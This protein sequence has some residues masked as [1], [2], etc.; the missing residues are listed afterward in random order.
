VSQSAW[1]VSLPEVWGIPSLPRVHCETDV[2]HGRRIARCTAVANSTNPATWFDVADPV[3]LIQHREA[4]P[5]GAELWYTGIEKRG[6]SGVET[7]GGEKLSLAAYLAALAGEENCRSKTFAHVPLLKILDPFPEPEKG[8]LY[9]EVHTEKWETYIIT[10]VDR[11]VW[12]DGRGRVLFGFSQEKID[13]FA[14]NEENFKAALL[15]DAK[16]Y[17]SVR[18][19]L[20]GGQAVSEELRSQEQAAW[21]RLRTYFGFLEVEPGS[22]VRVPPFIPHSL[23]NGVR[24]VEFQTPTYERLILAFNQRVLTQNHWDSEDALQRSVFKSTQQLVADASTFSTEATSAWKAVV[25][26][27]EFTVQRAQV[28]AHSALPWGSRSSAHSLLFVVEGDVV[29]SD[30]EGRGRKMNATAGDA[31]LLPAGGA[32]WTVKSEKASPAILLSV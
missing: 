17:E 19:A 6:V 16:A 32:S 30:S 11:S 4:K 13:A 18:R 2:V 23:Q 26:F 29:L 8:C 25:A 24:V 14:G 31:L 1:T 27:P 7:T 15:Q 21:Q 10:S 28:G 3:K 20:D 5:W 12:P 22:I 9:I